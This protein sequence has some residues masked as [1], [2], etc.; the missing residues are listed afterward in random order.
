MSPRAH[1]EHV[2]KVCS[3]GW[4][5]W[6]K[7]SHA[8]YFSYKPRGGP[9]V[10]FSFDA[11]FTGHIDSK[12]EAEKKAATIRTAIDAGTFERSADRRAREQREAAER[13]ERE[14]AGLVT[15]GA[16]T[17]RLDSF[18]KTYIDRAAKASGK[19]TWANDEGMLERLCAFVP[20]EGDRRLGEWPVATMTVDTLETFFASLQALAV[21]TRNQYVQVLKAAFRWAVKK[22]YIPERLVFEDTIL[23][24]AKVAERRRR[25]SSHE[26]QNLLEAAGKLRH[27]AGVRLQWLIIAAIE[28]GL[29][30]GEL[31]ALQR[32]DVNLTKRTLDVRAIEVGAKKTGRARTL[33][34]ST[35][36][37]AILEMAKLD[38]AGREYG[39]HTYVFGELGER[40][41]SIKKAWETAVLRAHGHEPEWADGALAP[42]SRA[43]LRAANLHFHGK[44]STDRAT[45]C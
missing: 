32:R 6:P 35:R 18:V 5:Q 36:L 42:A 16:A 17:V 1:G 8:W 30:R 15:D 21:S 44:R 19:T 3:C 27:N 11:E 9:H 10:R 14:R 37:S 45:A 20:A 40:I 13:I 43:Q 22:A 2:R 31:I 34:I 29:R 12:V 25:V 39:P 26:E 28:T 38:P 7:C 4:R 23:K 41:G 33:P 24:R